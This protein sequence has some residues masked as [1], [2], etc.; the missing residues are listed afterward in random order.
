MS[1]FE[2]FNDG[3]SFEEF[4]NNDGDTYKEK[5]IEIYKSIEF[6]EELI[7]RIKNINKKINILACAE[8]WCP[9]CMINVPVLRKMKDYNENIDIAIVPKEGYEEVFKKHSVAG[10]IRIPTFVIYD[11][12]FN[13]LGS[14]VEY[15]KEI[16]NIVNSGNQPKIIVA[17]RKYRKGEYAEE[18]LKDILNIIY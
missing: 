8:I 6:S 2:I 12:E 16:K 3:I 17:K 4:V 9:D 10:G 15:P 7:N 1:L 5:T 18:T 11:E 14:F 13:E